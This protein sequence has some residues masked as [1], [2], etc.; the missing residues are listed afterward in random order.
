[1]KFEDEDV[2]EVVLLPCEGIEVVSSRSY[3]HEVNR[4]KKSYT[5]IVIIWLEI[6][7]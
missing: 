1:M 2:Y 7:Y 5:N 3:T 4:K 6:S